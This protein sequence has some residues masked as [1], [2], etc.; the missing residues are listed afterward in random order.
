MNVEIVNE[1]A[2]FFISGILRFKF[3]VQCICSACDKKKL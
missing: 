1:A 3:S 2:Q